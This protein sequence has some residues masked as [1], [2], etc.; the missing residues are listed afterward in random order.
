MVGLAT[1]AFGVL[2]I[3]FTIMGFMDRS[4]TTQG[5]VVGVQSKFAGE[6]NLYLSTVRFATE[7]GRSIVFTSNTGD[8]AWLFRIGESV[9][10]GYDPADPTNAREPIGSHGGRTMGSSSSAFCKSSGR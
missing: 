8:D 5:T 1:L 4:A 3:P 6:D 10:V 2:S 7:D 9:T